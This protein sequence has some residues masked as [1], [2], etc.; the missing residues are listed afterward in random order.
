MKF[1]V[2]RFLLSPSF[3]WPPYGIEQAIIFCPV[4]S[5]FFY[6]FF[7]RLISAVEG[8]MS[9]A[10]TINILVTYGALRVFIL[11]C[12]VPYLHTW[13]GLSA[14]LECMSEMGCMRLAEKYR[15]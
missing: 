14:N 6:L 13:C 11:Y 10:P 12:I 7:P 5:F 3:L 15:T 8:W 2:L 4:V 9:T 1:F